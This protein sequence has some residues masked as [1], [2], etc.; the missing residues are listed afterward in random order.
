MTDDELHSLPFPDTWDNTMRTLALTCP[1]KFYLFLRGF[2]YAS[3]PSYFA[4]GSAW[5]EILRTWYTFTS[6]PPANDPDFWILAGK[7]VKA[8]EAYWDDAG[9]PDDGDNNRAALGRIF[10]AYLE[11]Y[12]EEPFTL[13]PRGDESGWTWPLGLQLEGREMYLGGSIDLYID[14]P[15]YGT[16]PLE[17]KTSGTYL[18]ENYVLQ[19][20]FAPQITGYIWYVSQLLDQPCWG[21]LVNMVTKKIPGK[22]SNWSTPRFARTLPQKRPEA[23]IEFEEDFRA[24]L[25]RIYALNWAP[26][27]WPRTVDQSNCT[28]GVGKAPCLF[29]SFCLTNVP[30]KETDPLTF[31]GIALRDGPWEPWKRAGGE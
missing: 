20:E 16:L 5:H 14:W 23:L 30:Y 8:G 12:P 24:D 28:G 3:R 13:I 6:R 17:N 18:G 11:Q 21:C 2:D 31:Q 10:E 25:R 9:A 26:W 7:A 22:R 29:K 4:W 27:R 19:W 15:P 1:R